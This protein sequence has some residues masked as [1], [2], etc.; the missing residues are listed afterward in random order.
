MGIIPDTVLTAASKE[1]PGEWLWINPPPSR[2]AHP[3]SGGLD[4]VRREVEELRRLIED[5]PIAHGGIGHNR[6]PNELRATPEERLS[7]LSDIRHIEAAL[8]TITA[9]DKD[10]LKA[11]I[12]NV[13]AYASKM[14]RSALRLIAEGALKEAGKELWMYVQASVDIMQLAEHIG[15]SLRLF[16]GL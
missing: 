10:R 6:P 3:L 5:T 14:G 2:I 13:L 11:P 9:A 8:P 4:K 7:V 1:R 16:L 15:T 12:A